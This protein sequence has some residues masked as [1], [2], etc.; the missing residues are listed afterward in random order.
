MSVS[1]YTALSELAAG[2]PGGRGRNRLRQI[3]FRFRPSYRVGDAG[4][5]TPPSLAPSIPDGAAQAELLEVAK[6][7]G[8]GVGRVDVT[9]DDG[10]RRQVGTAFRV[11]RTP[12]RMLT[13]RHLLQ[14]ML[15]PGHGIAQSRPFRALDA[16]ER[17]IAPSDALNPGEVV[18]SGS[19]MASRR[20]IDPNLVWVHPR[21]D[22]MLF[23]L[24]PCA[25]GECPDADIEILEIETGLDWGAP[26]WENDV[27]VMGFPID[28][29]TAPNGLVA[30][31]FFDGMG[32]KYLSP[33]RARFD[34]DLL[35]QASEIDGDATA[36]TGNADRVLGRHDAST[37]PGHSGSPVFRLGTRKVLGVHVVP[38][39]FQSQAT[40]AGDWHVPSEANRFVHLAPAFLREP[41]L[42]AAAMDPAAPLGTDA[43]WSPDPASSLGQGE[44]AASLGASLAA[45]DSAL[46]QAV[47]ADMPDIRDTPFLPAF[48]TV[49]D[50]ILPPRAQLPKLRTQNV[51]DCVG[52]ALATAID[53]Q[54]AR[55][56][57]DR[58]LYPVSARMIYET[59]RIYDEYA[60]DA[61]GGTSLRGALKGLFHSGVCAEADEPDPDKPWFL[62]IAR[63][64]AAREV[65]LTAYYRLHA[66]ISDFQY[67]IATAGAV[68][69]SARTHLGW[70][71]DRANG[72]IPWPEREFG[73]H[74]F[75]LIGYDRDGF[76]VRNSWGDDW[77]SVRGRRGVALWRYED[78]RE[79]LIDAWVLQLAPRTPK[80]FEVPGRVARAASD[81]PAGTLHNGLAALPLPRRY[82][83][84]GHCLHA[85]RDGIVD[86][87]RLGMGL[88]GLRETALYLD[89]RRNRRRYRRIAFLCHDPFLTAEELAR[90]IG[91]LIV[92]F[93]RDGIYPVHLVYGADEAE[94]IRLRLAADAAR[95]RGRITGSGEDATEYLY[96]MARRSCRP[97][98]AAFTAGLL[99]AGERG[100]PVW[101]I[102]R[103]LALEAGPFGTRD[104]DRKIDLYALGA[105]GLV[106]DRLEQVLASIEG[107]VIAGRHDLAALRARAT[108]MP[109]ST[110]SLAETPKSNDALNG[111][112]T[113]WPDLLRILAPELCTIRRKDGR[114]GLASDLYAEIAQS[115]R[116]ASVETVFCPAARHHDGL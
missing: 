64:R 47:V 106:A 13:C 56:G 27:C 102:A 116:R 24:L 82:N 21:W 61:I 96:G 7:C 2:H 91:E 25:D 18:F 29:R 1:E 44:T 92:P 70:L 110:Y 77:S 74:A 72:R 60:G 90:L 78:W 65:R 36:V 76:Y 69:V 55:S 104:R 79:N 100:G 34:P 20:R 59:A 10:T 14:R 48:T 26:D 98:F 94:T 31:V 62:D 108:H 54:L 38:G 33:G 95:L 103:S 58:T 113:D 57:A 40:T 52:H 53:I 66:S 115:L 5:L 39:R 46:F 114:H 42:G 15:R 51:S 45:E 87:G 37:L 88:S 111:F 101:Q 86:G 28:E 6:S 67:A 19:G 11:A 81:D 23:D 30:E 16:E 43:V 3:I 63:A 22:L 41:A 105:G 112:R 8:A 84:L 50:T 107:A 109:T 68:V 89:E 32:K 35:R 93:K 97:L 73:R 12:C 71:P 99:A 49:P 75:A 83:L 9:L 17:S 80:A 85:E 4:L